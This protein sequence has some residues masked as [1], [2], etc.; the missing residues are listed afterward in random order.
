MYDLPVAAVFV[1]DA[2]RRQFEPAP[3]TPPSPPRRSTRAVRSLR[4]ATSAALHRA[5]QAV[6]P[7][8]EC[9]TAH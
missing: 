1:R 4:L 8:P 2:M 7:P 9:T 6:A 3:P 5:A